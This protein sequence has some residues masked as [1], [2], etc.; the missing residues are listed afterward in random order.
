[1][2][3]YS[4][5]IMKRDLETRKNFTERRFGADKNANGIRRYREYF[6]Q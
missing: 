1:M 6:Y 2:L 3:T 5:H 4:H